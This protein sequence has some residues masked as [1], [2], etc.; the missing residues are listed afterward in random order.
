M[1]LFRVGARFTKRYVLRL[2]DSGS[3]Y[4]P[5][6]ILG[7]SGC[8]S[9]C[10]AQTNFCIPNRSTLSFGMMYRTPLLYSTAGSLTRYG[11]G[12]IS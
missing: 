1:I 10:F 11:L 7:G 9:E 2:P 12:F 6:E 4:V 3:R 5:D 8:A